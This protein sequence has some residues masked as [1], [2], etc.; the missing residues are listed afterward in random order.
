MCLLANERYET[1]QMGFSFGHLGHAT[2]VGLGG[3]CTVEV[4]RLKNCF[5]KIQPD[6]VCELH[7]WHMQ[8]HNFGSP[9]LGA[10]WSVQ[11]VKYH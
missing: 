2:G 11:K 3:T 8:R 10:L 4:A 1:Y 9:P 5:S 7:G 6:L